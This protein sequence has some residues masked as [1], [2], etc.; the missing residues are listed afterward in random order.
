MLLERDPEDYKFDPR[1]FQDLQQE[2]GNFTVDL[3]ADDEGANALC[4]TYYS[5]SNSVLKHNLSG[6]HCW[7]NPPFDPDFVVSLLEHYHTCKAADPAH[8]SACF[9]L[10]VWHTA[11]WWPLV[12]DMQIVRY[13]PKGTKLFNVAAQQPQSQCQ[14]IVPVRWP[15]LVLRD[16]AGNPPPTHDTRQATQSAAAQLFSLHDKQQLIEVTATANHKPCTVLIDCGATNDFI[17]AD[18]VNSQ[19]LPTDGNP[20]DQVVIL[21]N[22]QTQQCG[23]TCTVLLKMHGYQIRRK[24][25][26]TNLPHHDVILGMP[27]LTEANPVLDFQRRT[28]TVKHGHKTV[29]LQP[30]CASSHAHETIMTAKQLQRAMR[31][32]DVQVLLVLLEP[33]K[34]GLDLPKDTPAAVEPVLQEFKDV[35]PADL[36][37][38]MP[39]DRGYPHRIELEPG[40]EPP[41]KSPYRLSPLE[42][43]ELKKQLQDL[44]EHEFIQPSTSPYGAPILFVKKKDGSLRM[45]VDYRM[46]NKITIKNKHPLPRIDELLDQLTGARYFTKLDLRS[47]YYQVPIAPGDIPK[48]AFRTRY[49][50]FEFRVMPFGL[51]NAPATFQAMMNHVLAPYVDK[52]VANLLDDILIYSKTL[53]E[54]LEH[55]R[56]VL[57]KLREFKLYVKLAKCEFAKPEV[58]FLGFVVGRDGLKASPLKLDAVRDWPEP[59]TV[60]QIRSFIGFC[61]FYRRFVKDYAHIAAP[62]VELT[63]RDAWSGA[64]G[65]D[66]RAAFQALKDRLTSAP[67][68][69]NPDFSK[70]FVVHVDACDFAVGAVL[71][72]DQGHGLQPVA[73]ESKKLSD[74]ERKWV[75]S[76]KEAFALVHACRV[77][78]PY[79]ESNIPFLV[80]SDNSQVTVPAD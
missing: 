62:L 28:C 61:N 14:Q 65:L 64:L 27:W 22:G 71:L 24:L 60:K 58:E 8:T 23:A 68:L 47:G 77:W 20:A 73:Y 25:Q 45:C 40:H 2:F 74:S 41:H 76:E 15:V 66:E 67:V 44:I 36:P 50:H 39:P 46:L 34:D 33:S 63:K 13:F 10:P 56:L 16:S 4:S 21:G 43:E 31:K 37:K 30:K 26:V 11:P 18:F 19:Q 48:T 3:T 17:S 7:C 53:E 72:Q 5:K 79:L 70:P 75:I 38:Q 29:V 59:T 80:R 35:F 1:E 54:H 49:G 42:L 51:T 57:G 69:L 12:K 55:L 52:F 9:V 6:H 32:P 78:R